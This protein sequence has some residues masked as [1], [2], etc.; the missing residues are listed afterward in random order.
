MHFLQINKNNKDVYIRL[1]N[2][3]KDAMENGKTPVFDE[4][5][6]ARSDLIECIPYQSIHA[7]F[8]VLAAFV[9]DFLK[10]PVTLNLALVLI[11]NSVFSCIARYIYVNVKHVM[12]V[13]CLRKLGIEPTVRNIGVME[14]MEYQCV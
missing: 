3:T 14:S 5:R 11:V 13:R 4:M 6:S 7:L 8:I 9:I 1:F 10:L 12:R 2:E